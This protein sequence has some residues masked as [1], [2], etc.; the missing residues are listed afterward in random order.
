MR[1]IPLLLGMIA[2]LLLPSAAGATTL[3]KTLSR[4]MS[5]AGASSGAYVMDSDTGKILFSRRATTPRSLA[6]NTKLFTSAAVLGRY[7]P[8]ASLATD[9]VGSGS[10]TTIR[11][12]AESVDSEILSATT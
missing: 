12:I 2:V 7:G 9:L 11:A 3:K 5:R 8:G 10:L 6:S 1:Q 4:A